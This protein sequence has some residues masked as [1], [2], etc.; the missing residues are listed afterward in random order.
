MALETLDVTAR[1][2][3]HIGATFRLRHASGEVFKR[4]LVQTEEAGQPGVI[5]EGSPVGR[6]LRHAQVGDSF[7]V[8]VRSRCGGPAVQH[9]YTVLAVEGQLDLAAD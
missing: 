8:E 2:D 4:T 6:H 3:G 1:L 9:N 5:T 7:T